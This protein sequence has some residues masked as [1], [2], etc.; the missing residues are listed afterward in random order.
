[1]FK[2]YFTQQPLQTYSQFK[3][4]ITER[5]FVHSSFPYT[6]HVKI[7]LKNSIETLATLKVS[8]VLRPLWNMM[9]E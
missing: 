6:I 5:L 2:I 3:K 7:I 9:R 1:M 4:L 8:I